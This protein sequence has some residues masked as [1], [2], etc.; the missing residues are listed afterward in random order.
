MMAAAPL[1]TA[2]A[3]DVPL[4]RKK[5]AL[6]LP[7]LPYVWSMYELGSRRLTIERPGATTSG[8]RAALPRLDQSGMT[9][10][11][12][13]V[14]PLLSSAPTEMTYGSTAGSFKRPSDEPP[15]PAATTT[16]IP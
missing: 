11:L 6:T 12:V 10:S 8:V 2:V 14:E 5:R 3:C 15:F 7:L 4:P 16:T 9:S 13:D 1:T